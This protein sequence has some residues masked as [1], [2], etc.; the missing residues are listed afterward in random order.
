MSIEL[1]TMSR[2]SATVGAMAGFF[3]INNII[4]AT[5]NTGT[6][7]VTNIDATT[8]MIFRNDFT[9]DFVLK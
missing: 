1:K 4:S 7:T 6:I 5:T 2:N 3:A 8:F 9:I